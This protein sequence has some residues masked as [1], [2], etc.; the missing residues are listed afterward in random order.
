MDDNR[1]GKY[2]PVT[3]LHE[4]DKNP[5]DA[6]PENENRLSYQIDVLGE[7][8]PLLVMKDGTVLGGNRRLKKYKE[9]GKQEIWTSEIDFVQEG[10]VWYA[11]LNGARQNKAFSTK[12]AGMLEYALSDNDEIGT[13]NKE[14]LSSLVQQVTIDSS[15]YA[16]SMGTPILVET[17]EPKGTSGGT[18][19]GNSTTQ[20]DPDLIE[21][22]SCG[23]KFNPDKEG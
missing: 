5:K 15:M 16:V 8:K 12:E 23:H 2:R 20:T 7:Y 18:G 11:V 1:T 6:T 4:W 17:F 13:Y 3:E 21:C 10:D 19:T 9:K 14:K 22:P